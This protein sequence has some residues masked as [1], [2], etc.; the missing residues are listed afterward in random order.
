MRGEA[1][2]GTDD[3]GGGKGEA[4]VAAVEAI[5]GGDFFGAGVTLDGGEDEEGGEGHDEVGEHVEGDD[6]TRFE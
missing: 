5:E 1:G 2:E 3:D 6:F 4:G